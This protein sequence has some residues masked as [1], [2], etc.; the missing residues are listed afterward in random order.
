VNVVVTTAMQEVWQER[1]VLESVSCQE[2]VRTVCV[3][4]GCEVRCL[5]PFLSFVLPQPSVLC[6]VV[7]PF[8]SPRT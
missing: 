6:V 8:L 7:N 2:S 1:N 5:S 3:A 4:E